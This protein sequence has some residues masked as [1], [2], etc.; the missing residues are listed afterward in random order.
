MLCCFWNYG[1]NSTSVKNATGF[2]PF[3]LV[4]CV[5]TIFPIECEI[6]SLRIAIQLLPETSALE[7][8]LVELEHLDETRR[9]AA[10][11]NEAHKHCVKLQYD[12][13]I[14]PRIFSEG[15][16]VLLYHQASDALGA[17]KFVAMWHG[18]YVVKRVLN[19]G[20]Y[21]LQDC[22]GGCLKE[23]CNGLYLK[24]YYA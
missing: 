2:T 8:R 24:K 21:E 11:T 6:P 12:K 7:A 4:Y 18:P 1:L 10:T 15:D 5:E 14:H 16:L 9:D 19:K 20:S 13:S 3:Q 22:E 23:P 17:G